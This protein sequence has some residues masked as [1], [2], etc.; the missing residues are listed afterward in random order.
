M[1]RIFGIGAVFVK[2]DVF[3]YTFVHIFHSFFPCG[4]CIFAYYFDKFA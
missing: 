1:L 2:L 3:G 4:R